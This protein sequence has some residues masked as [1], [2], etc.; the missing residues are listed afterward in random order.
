MGDSSGLLGSGT[1]WSSGPHHHSSPTTLGDEAAVSSVTDQPEMIDGPEAALATIRSSS[2]AT[3][4]DSLLVV[5]GPDWF[6]NIMTSDN[7]S[8]GI[9]GDVADAAA[10]AVTQSGTQVSVQLVHIPP[11]IC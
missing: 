1:G 11:K 9:D 8:V 5:G 6:K 2:A 10:V 3:D 7:H 4:D